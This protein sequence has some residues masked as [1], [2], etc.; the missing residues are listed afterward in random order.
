MI[1]IHTHILP[2]IDDGADTAQTSIAMLQKEAEQQV[3][4]VIL[5]PHFYRRNEKP[6]SFLDRRE[7]SYETLLE[8]IE[9]LPAEE[10]RQ[11]PKLHLGAEVAWLPGLAAVEHLDRMCLAETDFMLIELPFLPWS[12]KMID[13]LY[14]LQNVCGII[15]II[16]HF[17]R[18]LTFQKKEYVWRILE[19]DVP[20]QIGTE[21]LLHVF[22][23]KEPL[24][25]LREGA[26]QILASDCHNLNDRAPNLGAAMK[27]V[28]QKLGREYAE[29]ITRNPYEI[30][31][32]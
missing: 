2:H 30:L 14:D 22:G 19:M 11:L 28:E 24:R 3:D 12:G 15:P 32:D 23:R 13:Q 10:R 8:A 9:K 7:R 25:L 17:E 21:P 1:D 18:Y 29:Q 31:F 4:T 6:E 20:V 27:T 16:A 5:T 26:A